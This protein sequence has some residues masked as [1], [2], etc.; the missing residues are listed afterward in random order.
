MNRAKKF[1]FVIALAMAVACAGWAQSPAPAAPNADF[2]PF[3]QWMGA[4]LTGD[5]AA[6]KGLY[7]TDPAAQV[8]VKTQMHDADADISFWIGK[9]VR[10]MNVDLV[11]GTAP[12][13]DITH[14]ILRINMVTASSDGKPVLVTDDQVWQ[15]QGE[16]WKL[17]SVERTDAPSL[18]QPSDMKKEIYPASADAH[19]EIKEAEEKAA[20]DHKRVLLVFGANWCFDC[21]VLD[22]AFHGPELG[23]I[24]TTNYEVVHVDLGPD[25]K[26]NAD[27]V[28]QFDIPLNKGIPAMAIAD[29]DG[30]LIVSQ[31][32]GE[33]EDARQLTPEFLAEFLNKWKPQAQ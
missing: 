14:L 27:L 7:S 23:P 13:P 5:A 12:R 11:R 20:R 32:N 1:V 10:S 33:V 6:L 2:A 9:K 16:Q 29:S 15:K 3:Q 22:I 4:I 26:K 18:K 31:K 21:H 8:R 17:V 28:Q 19:A 24:V 30:K 25:E